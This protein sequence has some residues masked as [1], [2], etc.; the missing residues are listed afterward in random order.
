L[1]AESFV[2]TPRMKQLISNKSPSWDILEE[3]LA[4]GGKSI[5]QKAVE[6]CARGLIPFKLAIQFRNDET[7]RKGL[8]TSQL[9]TKN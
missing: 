9:I 1:L 8:V 2:A 5:Y 6:A 7:I 3:Q 4:Q